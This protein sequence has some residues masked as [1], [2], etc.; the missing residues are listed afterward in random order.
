MAITP[1]EEIVVTAQEHI[2]MFDAIASGDADHA[3]EVLVI[4]LE[5]SQKRALSRFEG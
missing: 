4:H 2:D 5:N 3:V 1:R